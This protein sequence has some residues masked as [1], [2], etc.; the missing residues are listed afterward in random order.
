MDRDNYEQKPVIHCLEC[1]KEIP[2]GRVNQLYCSNQCKDKH[3]NKLKRRKSRVKRQVL[4]ILDKNYTIL[5]DLIHQGIDEI[6]ITEAA[7]MGYNPDYVTYYRK[8]RRRTTCYCYDIRFVITEF[9]LKA[10][11]FSEIYKVETND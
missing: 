9:R 3:N 4:E 6:D 8:C 7:Q 11:S 10:I 2:Y 5:S 1:G